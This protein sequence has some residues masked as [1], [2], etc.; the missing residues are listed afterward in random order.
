[1]AK[2]CNFYTNQDIHH[3]LEHNNLLVLLDFQFVQMNVHVVQFLRALFQ[4]THQYKPINPDVFW[5]FHQVLLTYLLI[6]LDKF[7]IQFLL[8]FHF[9]SSKLGKVHPQKSN[10]QARY[11]PD[12]KPF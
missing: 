1:M 9:Y 7:P 10:G 11:Y 8:H 12:D 2:C 5:A 4:M 3:A 6:N